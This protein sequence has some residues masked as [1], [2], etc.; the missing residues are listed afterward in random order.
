MKNEIRYTLLEAL[1]ILSVPVSYMLAFGVT[2][3]A[4]P[5]NKTLYRAGKIQED[6]DKLFRKAEIR[7]K[8]RFYILLYR[9]KK[10]GLISVEDKN[11]SITNKGK[12]ALK[13]FSNK[14]N[15][16]VGKYKDKAVDSKEWKIILFDIPE[17]FKQKRDWLRSVLR[18]LE[19]RMVQRSVWV[20]NK[21]IPES[22]IEDLKNMEI[23]QFVEILSGVKKGSLG[24]EKR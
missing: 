4:E 7:E 9:L 8:R 19:F 1:N 10:D 17:S 6:F 23:L 3:R 15:V 2:L 16:P 24:V 13:S 18:E 12:D 14:N 5:I 22:L 11:I 21:E 20:G